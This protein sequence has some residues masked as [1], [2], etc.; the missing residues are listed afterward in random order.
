MTTHTNIL[1]GRIPYREGSGGLPWGHKESDMTE[2]LSTNLIPCHRQQ[3]LIEH[4]LWLLLLLNLIYPPYHSWQDLPGGSAVENPP[5]NQETLVLSLG[6]EDL[7]RRENGNPLQSSCLENPMDRG[8]WQPTAHRVAKRQAR[9]QWLTMQ[10]RTS[11]M[12]LLLT[13]TDDN[14]QN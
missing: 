2:C 6:Q 8:A 5:A 3:D 4:G 12:A 13:S 7:P 10:P 14:S 11:L 1:A 9:L